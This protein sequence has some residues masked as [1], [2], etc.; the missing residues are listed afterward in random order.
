M[1]SGWTWQGQPTSSSWVKR[2]APAAVWLATCDCRKMLKRG[3]EQLLI[4]AK[5]SS[6]KRVDCSAR[7]ASIVVSCLLLRAVTC[8]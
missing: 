1:E 8:L 4:L 7:M 2:R 5:R 3:A 6:Q